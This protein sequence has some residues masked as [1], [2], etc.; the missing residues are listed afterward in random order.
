MAKEVALTKI[1]KISK[2][3]Q[4][5]I[6]SVLGTSVILGVAVCL[7][8]HFIEK[9]SY[10]SKVIAEEEKS[11]ASYSDVIKKI[12]VCTSPR[13]SV[14]SDDELRKCDPATIETSQIPGTLRYNILENI[15]ANVALESVPQTD[16]TNCINPSTQKN[17]TFKELNDAYNR[18]DNAYDRKIAMRKIKTCSAL[19]VI[20]DALPAYKNE[21]ALL[22]SVNQIFNITGQLPES[23]SP[24]DDYFYNADTNDLSGNVNPLEVILSLEADAAVITT[25][26]QNTELSIREFDA[27]QASF[28]WQDDNKLNLS[29]QATAYYVDEANIVETDKKVA[30]G[31]N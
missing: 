12:G 3:Q 31:G 20:P 14:Y 2:A 22:A 1:S 13:G 18:T 15:A 28:E 27:N 16:N 25:F 4:Y 9:I 19:R 23:L 17:Y 6:L 8:K 5:M 29:L 10:N 26:L 30:K 11:I 7:N 24:A 21:E